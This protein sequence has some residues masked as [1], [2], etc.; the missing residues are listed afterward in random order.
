[1][2][3]LQDLD[4]SSRTFRIAITMLYI[5]CLAVLSLTWFVWSR[6]RYFVSAC[7]ICSGII[8]AFTSIVNNYPQFLVLR[9]LLGLF[10]STVGSGMAQYMARF[11][12]KS[13]LATRLAIVVVVR[14]ISTMIVSL[15]SY[16]IAQHPVAS[17]EP[18]RLLTLVCGLPSL[19]VGPL[20][21]LFLYRSPENCTFL[22][23]RQRRI[24]MA[25]LDSSSLYDRLPRQKRSPLLDVKVWVPSLLAFIFMICYTSYWLS[26]P[27]ILWFLGYSRQESLALSVPLYVVPVL[28]IVAMTYFTNRYRNR[29][30]VITA[31]SL[32]AAIG[33]I[34]MANPQVITAGQYVGLFIAPVGSLTAYTI[35]LGWILENLTLNNNYWLLIFIGLWSNLGSIAGIWVYSNKNWVIGHWTLAAL[36]IFA[37]LVCLLYRGYLWRHSNQSHNYH[38]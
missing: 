16:P 22:T 15:I 34:V 25:R 35:T 37:S 30:Y 7:I 23:Y 5:G 21:L 26:A 3:M 8:T 10:Q 4:L 32:I 1:M 33:Y 24:L 31:S 13:E 12:T 14:P 20:G 6:P 2:G 18:W 29:A 28:A 36:L 11:Y 38:L 19:I 27:H 17:I 9:L